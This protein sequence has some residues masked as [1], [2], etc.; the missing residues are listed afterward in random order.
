VIT[1]LVGWNDKIFAYCERGL[2]PG[3]LAEPLNAASNLAFFAAA[4]LAYREWRARPAGE[5]GAIELLLIGLAVAIGVG[6]TLFH[7][8]A[9]RWGAVTDTAP[10][11]IFMLLYL[12]YAVRRYLA[13]G[14]VA[15]AAAL[16]AFLAG[17]GVAGIP[18]C[19]AHPC[20]NGSLAYAPALT[21]LALAAGAMG[22]T[23]HPGAR[24]M[25][26]AAAVFALAFTARSLDRA[27]CDATTVSV[28]GF[29]RRAL[30]THAVWH[31]LNGILIY[32]LLITAV[33]HGRLAGA[34]TLERASGPAPRT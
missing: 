30:G 15:A 28:L 6:S 8:F 31:T 29:G 17:M 16:A 34:A 21:A 5:R 19:G 13:G 11:G 3:L 14:A 10:I 23:R 12:A 1:P 26:A 25:M 24:L 33:R 7:T 4:A 20:L 22:L 9:T 32:L 18:K 27:L 2:D